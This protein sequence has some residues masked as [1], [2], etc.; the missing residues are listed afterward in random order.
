MSRDQGESLSLTDA[1]VQLSFLVQSVIEEACAEHG[2]SAGQ[3]RLLG[4]LEGRSPAM[5]ELAALLGVERASVTGLVDR[6][7][8]R[9]LVRRTP[10]PGDRRASHV[11]LTDQGRQTEAAFRAS[12][13]RRIESLTAGLPSADRSHLAR[14]ATRVLGVEA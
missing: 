6:A 13:A 14:L 2:T 12:V 5:T 11:H 8:R 3:A 9:G 1:L 7:E 10:N 4:V